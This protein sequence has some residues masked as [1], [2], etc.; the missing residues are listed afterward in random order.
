M[1]SITFISTVHNKI[2]KCSA[3]ELCEILIKITPEVVFLEALEDTYSKYQQHTFSNFGVFHEKLEIRALQKYS[4]ISQFEYVPV[5]GQGLTD[6]FEE[7]FNLVCQNIHFRKMLDNFNSLASMKG[8]DFLNSEE[9]IKL[10]EEMR[11]YGDSII[12]DNELIQTF[13]NDIDK[14]ENSMISN[15][16]SFGMKTKFKNAVFMCGVAHRQSIIDKIETYRSKTSL[17]LNW[18]IYGHL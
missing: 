18:K 10:Y 4:G 14:Y 9:S 8:F 17:D 3:N 12:M 7:K 5:L 16:Y 6:S 11:I 15:I 1:Q 2:G 13:K